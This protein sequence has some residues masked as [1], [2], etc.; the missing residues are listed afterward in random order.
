MFDPLTIA[1]FVAL[2]ALAGWSGWLTLRS[3]AIDNPLFY[4]ACLA[5]VLLIVQLV[6]GIARIHGSSARMS[7][8]VFIAYLAGMVL[9]LP[10]AAFWSFA[11]RETRWG[12][13]VLLVATLGLMVMV[14]RLV[15]LWG[16]HA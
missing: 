12:T 10:V 8:A 14:V 3:R 15:Q 11:E 2:A 9:V 4:L 1:I 13:G 16:G 7:H 5:E 6:T